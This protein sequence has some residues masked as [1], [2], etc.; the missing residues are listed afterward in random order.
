M[1]TTSILRGLML[2]TAIAVGGAMPSAVAHAGGLASDGAGDE[3]GAMQARGYDG[4]VASE[5]RTGQISGAAFLSRSIGGDFAGFGLEGTSRGISDSGFVRD[6]LHH[7]DRGMPLGYYDG[8]SH[9]ND[10]A[11]LDREFQHRPGICE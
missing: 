6:H 3:R 2:A 5:M 7:Q 9:G 8:F 1:R 4:D 11:L 10:C